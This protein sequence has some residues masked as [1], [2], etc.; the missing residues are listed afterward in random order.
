M[1]FAF[2][3]IQPK[4]CILCISVSCPLDIS[5]KKYMKADYSPIT[6][7]RPIDFVCAVISFET[8][9]TQVC[10]SVYLQLNTAEVGY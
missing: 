7:W 10:G 2:R 1:S 6:L 9:F 3:I 4:L 8:N 5:G